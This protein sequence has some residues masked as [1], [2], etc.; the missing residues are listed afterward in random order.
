MT[1]DH[2]R[3]AQRI[4]RDMEKAMRTVKERA[5]RS[6]LRSGSIE[7]AMKTI[8]RSTETLFVVECDRLNKT[9]HAVKER[10][11]ACDGKRRCLDCSGKGRRVGLLMETDCR[12]CKG[13]GVCASCVERAN[14][15]VAVLKRACEYAE[16]REELSF[17]GT[18][19]KMRI[20]LKEAAIYQGIARIAEGL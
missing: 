12:R 16:L 15:I 20:D 18:L 10:C 7:S 2:M 6:A 19:K 14:L 13:T 5:T 17:E 3:A 9:Y 1:R 11:R 8:D 4:T